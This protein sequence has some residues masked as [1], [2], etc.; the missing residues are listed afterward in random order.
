MLLIDFGSFSINSEKA[1]SEVRMQRRKELYLPKL[2]G[3]M[4]ELKINDT[5]IYK[6]V[7][8]M[9]IKWL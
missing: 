5:H 4:S 1:T 7:P 2:I 8:T 3:M 6:N 9:G